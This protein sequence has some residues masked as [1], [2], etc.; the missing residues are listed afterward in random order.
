MLKKPTQWWVID[1]WIRKFILIVFT[2]QAKRSE[3]AP[4]N[5]IQS[6]MKN[7]PQ[8]VKNIICSN[9]WQLTVDWLINAQTYFDWLTDLSK[10]NKNLL[11]TYV[12]DEYYSFNLIQPAAP[13]PK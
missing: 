3:N 4:D 2:L 13:F 12:L 9:I 5:Q 8:V 6:N 11:H 1:D 10:T 7:F